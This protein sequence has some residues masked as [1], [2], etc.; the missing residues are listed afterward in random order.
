MY[1]ANKIMD[2]FDL[3]Y[4]FLKLLTLNLLSFLLDMGLRFVRVYLNLSFKERNA[5]ELQR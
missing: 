5:T 4:I 2:Y 3:R 1:F